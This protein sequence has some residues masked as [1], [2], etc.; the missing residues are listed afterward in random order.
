MLV[1]SM[2]ATEDAASRR[3]AAVQRPAIVAGRAARV[4]AVTLDAFG[5][6]VELE[7]PAERLQAALAERGVERRRDSVAGAFAE[8]VAYYVEHKRFGRDEESLSRLRRECAAVFLHAAGAE[9]EPEEF[10]RPFVEALVFRPLDGVM[11]ALERLRGAGLVLVCVSDWDVSLAAQ[12]GRVGLGHILAAVVSS[13][14]V[15]VEKPDPAV[16]RAALLRVGVAPERA[17]HVGDSHADQAGA[18]AAGLAFEPAP[19]ATLPERLGL[20]VIP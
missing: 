13:A 4:D 18:E 8:E 15:G 9:L 6:L 10:T 3:F 7:D 1:E 19:V 5:T 16:F 11:P 12:L 2:C 20:P 14:E 17:L